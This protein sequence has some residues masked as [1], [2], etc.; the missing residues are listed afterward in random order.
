MR[1]S[2]ERGSYY[3]KDERG[4]ILHMCDQVALAYDRELGCLIKHGSPED[5]KKWWREGREKAARLF[6]D[7][8]IV[9]L[10][11]GFDVEEVNRCI[12]TSG[13]VGLLAKRLGG[14]G[15]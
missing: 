2:L 7:I 1:Y 6:E 4:N 15:G 5:V 8:V 9:T 13:Y 14:E 11:C 10:P 3:L 12:T